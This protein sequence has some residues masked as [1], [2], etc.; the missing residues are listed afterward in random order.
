MAIELGVFVYLPHATHHCGE[1]I[2]VVAVDEC[3]G[4]EVVGD[5]GRA[6]VDWDA[7][8]RKGVPD[9]FGDIA[10]PDNVLKGDGELVAGHKLKQVVKTLAELPVKLLQGVGVVQ[11][12]AGAV[13]PLVFAQL[14]AEVDSVSD[15]CQSHDVVAIYVVAEMRFGLGAVGVHFWGELL[16]EHGLQSAHMIVGA[17]EIKICR[18]VFLKGDAVV[19]TGEAVRHALLGES[20]YE[21]ADAPLE[22]G[23][24]DLGEDQV[25]LFQVGAEDQQICQT[26][27]GGRGI[28]QLPGLADKEIMAQAFFVQELAE[29][30]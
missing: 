16:L 10:L 17:G 29:V 11:T 14:T 3:F 22:L 18:G 9:F 28:H 12:L 30:V 4:V 6:P 23:T 8:G 15:T 21:R 26:F 2:I 7:A 25:V 19:K 13:N 24:Q 27:I 1:V 20:D 5:V